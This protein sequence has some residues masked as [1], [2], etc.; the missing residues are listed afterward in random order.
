MNSS[1]SIDGMVLTDDEEELGMMINDELLLL[2]VLQSSGFQS[3]P[4]NW[5]RALPTMWVGR[6]P[7]A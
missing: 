6:I 1:S 7:V 5:N 4:N 2:M 3:M